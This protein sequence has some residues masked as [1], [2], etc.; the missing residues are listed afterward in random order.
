MAPTRLLEE[1]SSIS[2]ISKEIIQATSPSTKELPTFPGSSTPCSPPTLSLP[3]P[4]HIHKELLARNIP[5]ETIHKVS[6]LYEST[7]GNF[8]QLL[9]SSFSEAW[10]KI[11]SLPRHDYTLPLDQLGVELAKT[12]EFYYSA[13]MKNWLEGLYE[14]IALP[15][16]RTNTD[17]NEVSLKRMPENQ[18]T[19][20]NHVCIYTY[21]GAKNLLT[22]LSQNYVP[23]LDAYFEENATPS[24]AQKLSLAAQSGMSYRQIHVWVCLELICDFSLLILCKHSFRTGENVLARSGIPCNPLRA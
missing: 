17:C 21:C 20:F 9:R 19:S 12:Y 1:L 11:V 16:A 13:K 14:R 24:R 6:L 18:R 8:Q 2:S 22:L 7:L 23:I 4:S 3:S 5:P 15:S 10:T